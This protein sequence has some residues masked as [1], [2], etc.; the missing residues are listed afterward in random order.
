MM[1][2]KNCLDDWAQRIGDNGSFSSWMLARSRV[3]QGS[4]RRQI[5][6]NI[7][8]SNLEK[9]MECTLSK[10]AD[11]VKLQGLEGHQ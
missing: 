7:F 2:V 1:W 11:D 10:S 3:L 8:I 6:F 5:L 9:A 4:S